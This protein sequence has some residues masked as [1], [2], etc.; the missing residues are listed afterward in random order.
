MR[1][2]GFSYA[3]P[4]DPWHKRLFI[5]F[6]ERISG[7]PALER[8]YRLNQTS[9]R[10]GESFWQAC[11][12]ALALRP[13]YDAAA[14]ERIPKTGPLVV[15]ANHPYGVL[16]GVLI[17]WLIEKV[18]SDFVVIVHSALLRAPESREFVLPVDFLET[19]EAR[20][21]NLKT[22][23]AA[24]ERLER[25]GAVIVFPA[26]MISTAPDALGR[27]PAVEYPWQPFVAQLIQRSRATVAP[28]GFAGQNSWL[29][30]FASHVNMTLRLA[31]IFHE[32]KIRIGRPL[33]IGVGEPIPHEA[34]RDIKD[35]QALADE[36]RAR[37]LALVPP[38]PVRGRVRRRERDDYG[39]LADGA[40]A[41]RVSGAAN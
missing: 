15:V 24:R 23:T 27:E 32:V 3:A 35:R 28:I 11:V 29:F 6:V 10:P 33:F 19:A 25:G 18:R 34:L 9:P 1:D 4:S 5:R 31:L 21:T 39:A 40:D 14:L 37:T 38:T 30:Q 8:L 26:G 36:L 2:I 16:D 17:C 20:A 13:I 41:R 12:R 22:R 7:Q